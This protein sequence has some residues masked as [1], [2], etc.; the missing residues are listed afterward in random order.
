MGQM[1]GR[2]LVRS[3]E[4]RLTEAIHDVEECNEQHRQG[5]DDKASGSHPERALGHILPTREEMRRDRQR[6][7]CRRQDDEAAHQIRKCS[8]TTQLN[9]SE[10][11]TQHRAQ[12]DCGDGATQTFIHAAEELGKGGGVITC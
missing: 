6:I 5:V 1:R 3:K 8:L 7:T 11:G 2:G 9:G 10:S 12:Q 4:F